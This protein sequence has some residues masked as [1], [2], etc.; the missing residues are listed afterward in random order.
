MLLLRANMANVLK[1]QRGQL[2]FACYNYALIRFGCLGL[3]I[4]RPIAEKLCV[5]VRL[6]RFV[7]D[8]HIMGQGSAAPFSG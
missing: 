1:A 4:I 3:Y 5:A 2:D 7:N 6:A 8:W